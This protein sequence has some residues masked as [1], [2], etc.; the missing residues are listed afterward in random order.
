MGR[1]YLFFV[2]FVRGLVFDTTHHIC[3]ALHAPGQIPDKK[4][5]SCGRLLGV[6]VSESLLQPYFLWW[7]YR[8]PCAM[9]RDVNDIMWKMQVSINWL[10]WVTSSKK[11]FECIAACVSMTEHLLVHLLRDINRYRANPKFR[12]A[13]L[14]S[15]IGRDNSKLC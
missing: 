1:H 13:K 8:A 9:P 5:W 10:L 15:G 3:K 12:E 14:G 7:Q 2:I 11:A 4:V 6:F